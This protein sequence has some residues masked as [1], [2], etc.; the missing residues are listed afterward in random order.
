MIDLTNPNDKNARRSLA[1]IDTIVVHRIDVG[2]TGEAIREAF[3]TGPAGN[4]TGHKVP[5]TFVVGRHGEVW[6]LLALDRVGPHALNWNK[7]SVGVAFIGDFR[8]KDRPEVAQ[9]AWGLVTVRTLLRAL[10]LGVDSVRAHDSL[11]EGSTDPHKECP[12][13]RFDLE[14]FRVQLA[15][16]LI[17]SSG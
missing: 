9:W 8:A 2:D 6:Q 4:Y 5:Y 14:A 12:G 3:L 16:G 1:D 15:E 7:R 13:R 10:G 17:L 11:P